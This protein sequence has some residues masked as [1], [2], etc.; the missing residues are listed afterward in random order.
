MSPSFGAQWEHNTFLLEIKKIFF[1]R[2]GE[3]SLNF[4]ANC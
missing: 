2:H 3:K 4:A 1:Y